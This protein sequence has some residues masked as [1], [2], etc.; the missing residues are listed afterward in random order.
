M[1]RGLF[2]TGNVV[3][4]MPQAHFPFTG[5]AQIDLNFLAISNIDWRDANT[6]SSLSFTFALPP[7]ESFMGWIKE[8]PKVATMESPLTIS[9]WDTSLMGAIEWPDGRHLFTFEDGIIS[10]RPLMGGT[11]SGYYSLID[12]SV[13][14]S[15]TKGFPIPIDVMGVIGPQ[16]ISL[17]VPYIE[18]DLHLINAVMAEPI[19]DFISGKLEGSLWVD[20]PIGEPEF[21]GTLKGDY[22]DMTTFWT[23][24]EVFSLKNPVV[25]ISEQLATVAASTV[26]AIHSGGRRSRVISGALSGQLEFRLLPGNHLQLEST[27]RPLAPLV[28]TQPQCRDQRFGYLYH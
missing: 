26:S 6:R 4:E 13:E 17:E 21:Y 19:L 28:G 22:L 10:V 18:L 12:N 5:T 15:A 3:L 23:P 8:V 11:L 14:F 20:G 7:Q 1:E 2:T 9:H 27:H 16:G 25:T 24:E